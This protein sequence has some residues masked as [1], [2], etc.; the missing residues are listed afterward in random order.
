[1]RKSVENLLIYSA[2]YARVHIGNVD[3]RIAKAF[4]T[5]LL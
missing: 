1:M 4:R 2:W 3:I 5:D